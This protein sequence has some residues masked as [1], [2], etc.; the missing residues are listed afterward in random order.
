[1]KKIDRLILLSFFSFISI[2]CLKEETTTLY[3][4]SLR[5]EGDSCIIEFRVHVLRGMAVSDGIVINYI[6][7]R[8]FFGYDTSIIRVNTFSITAKSIG[9]TSIYVRHP[10][11]DSTRIIDTLQVQIIKTNGRLSVKNYHPA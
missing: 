7:N 3:G 1:M 8:V 5:E 4:C 10:N 6:P 9:K 11:P 2:C